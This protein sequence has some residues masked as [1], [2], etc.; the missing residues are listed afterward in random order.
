VEGGFLGYP[1]A[2]T[3]VS[4]PPW[5]ANPH[6][7]AM[8]KQWKGEK[9]MDG[10][11]GGGVRLHRCLCSDVSFFNCKLNIIKLKVCLFQLK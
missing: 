7:P 5:L 11:G 2:S 9:L 6:N 3:V 10:R 1:G 4:Q 8:M